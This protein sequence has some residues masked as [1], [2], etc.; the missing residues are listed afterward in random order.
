VEVR[1][2]ERGKIDRGDDIS[3]EVSNLVEKFNFYPK[4]M[5]KNG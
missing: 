5:S 4:R 3:D 2:R 1:E